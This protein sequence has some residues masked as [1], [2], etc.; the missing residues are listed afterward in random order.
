MLSRPPAALAASIRRLPSVSSESAVLEQRPQ[1]RLVDHRGEAVGAEQ[2]EVAG[3]GRED[4]DVHLHAGLGAQRAGDHG[5]L[6]VLLGLLL[7]QLAA[8]HELADQRVVLG[9]AD[10]LAVAQQIGAGVADVGD[11]HLV[12]VDV[13]GR[14]RRA[15]AVQRLVRPRLVVDPL[16]GLLDDA[17]ERL[18]ERA[19]GQLV[20]ERAHRD[21]RRDLAGLRPAHA[22]GD[23][24]Q[25]RA[26]EEVVLVA[27]ALTAE[28]GGVPVLCD[29]Q[30]AVGC[31]GL[32]LE[33]ELGVTDADAVAHVQWLRPAHRLPVEIGP[34]G[35][36]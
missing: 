1:L 30:H 23:H 10:E 19:V 13:G 15:H 26:H 21:L 17:G 12:V 36:A 28:V 11:D 34:V 2:E 33:G 5:A 35:R 29:A 4:V 24:E 18:G 20:V 27:L 6:R 8:G 7:G 14:R 31:G 3:L 9:Q 25:R 32:A 22:V 16:V